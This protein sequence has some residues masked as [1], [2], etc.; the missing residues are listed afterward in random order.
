[1]PFINTRITKEGAT[2]EQKLIEGA[3]Q[4]PADAPGENPASPF[5]IIDEAETGNRGV[6]GQTVAKLRTGAKT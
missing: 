6:G 4:L 1:M 2:A 3:A 5:V